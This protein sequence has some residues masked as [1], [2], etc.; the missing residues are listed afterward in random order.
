MQSKKENLSRL[1]EELY[2]ISVFTP[3]PDGV[4]TIDGQ[5]NFLQD[6]RVAERCREYRD[7]GFTEIIFS[8]ETKYCGEPFENS[9]LKRMLD[10]AQGG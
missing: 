6:F 5:K 7:C 8:G 10:L 1:I 3:P 9:Q 4:L 2:P